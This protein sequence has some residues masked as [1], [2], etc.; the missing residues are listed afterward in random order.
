MTKTPSTKPEHPASP[1]TR[2]CRIDEAT[3]LCQG[4]RRTLDEIA[5]WAGMTAAERA[6]VW[7]RL[8]GE[9][10]SRSS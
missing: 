2:V 8:A 6:A 3:G 1:C 10:Q 4:C 9:A 5:R 7:A